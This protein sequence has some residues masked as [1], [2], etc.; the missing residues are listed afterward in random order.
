M[1]V[2]AILKDLSK[3]QQI[4]LMT[5]PKC[6]CVDFSQNFKLDHVPSFAF[7]KCFLEEM[8]KDPARKRTVKMDPG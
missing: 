6:H 3:N 4:K 5:C 2:L 7:Q 1:T 8:S